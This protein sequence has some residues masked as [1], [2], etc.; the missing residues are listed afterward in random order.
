MTCLCNTKTF[1]CKE[2]ASESLNSS[3]RLLK[4]SKLFCRKCLISFH[5]SFL[6]SHR[7]NPTSRRLMSGSLTS[8]PSSSTSSSSSIA[9]SATPVRLA[10]RRPNYAM[11]NKIATKSSWSS[12]NHLFCHSILL[13]L[14]LLLVL[15]LHAVVATDAVVVA[16]VVVVAAAGAVVVLTTCCCCC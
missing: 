12:N 16:V 1:L 10:S 14:L 2:T 9:P 11:N 3:S 7:N 4:W 13:L 8:G 15:S 6:T 5:A